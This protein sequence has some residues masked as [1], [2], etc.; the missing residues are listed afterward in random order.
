MHTSTIVW[1]A[2]TLAAH[3]APV[4]H[5]K[6]NTTV[7]RRSEGYEIVNVGGDPSPV[8]APVM[9]TVTAPG[10]PQETVTIT[11]SQTSL[12]TLAPT[13]TPSLPTPCSSSSSSSSSLVPSPSS[14]P[15]IETV[16]RR[17]TTM[18]KIAR[19]FGK[20]IDHSNDTTSQVYVRSSNETSSH[21]NTRGTNVTEHS[22]LPRGLLNATDSGS[23]KLTAR[24]SNG[25]TLQARNLTQ[26]RY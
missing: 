14:A 10:P 11:I 7:E 9:E 20:S 3:A 26:G 25:T 8:V 21:L 16:R 19:M 13:W 2:L 4:L 18:D 1:L 6:P 15:G 22:L 12:P 24:S 23:T 5:F 17:S